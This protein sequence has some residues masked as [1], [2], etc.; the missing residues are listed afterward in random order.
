MQTAKASPV[1]DVAGWGILRALG[2]KRIRVRDDAGASHRVGVTQYVTKQR[3]ICPT[4][5]GDFV[6]QPWRRFHESDRVLFEYHTIA[7]QGYQLPSD[8]VWACSGVTTKQATARRSL[9]HSNRALEDPIGTRQDA[10]RWL[11]CRGTK[12]A[13]CG[14][15]ECRERCVNLRSGVKTRLRIPGRIA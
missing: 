11:E 1:F 14:L 7:Q 13:G 5:C 2:R 8:I 15:I 12:A 10:T 9:S 3:P 4:D 6:G